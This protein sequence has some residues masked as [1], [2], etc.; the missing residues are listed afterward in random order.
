MRD[1]TWRL[2]VF[3]NRPPWN[4]RSLRVTV[5]DLVWEQLCSQPSFAASLSFYFSA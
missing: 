5:R 3:W 4:L 1:S 2:L